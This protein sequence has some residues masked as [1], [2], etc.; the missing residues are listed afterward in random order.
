MI[1][2]EVQEESREKLCERQLA[3]NVIADDELAEST[4]FADH[5]C[6]LSAEED[7]QL[8]VL[9][10]QQRQVSL[11]VRLDWILNALEDANGCRERI[12]H[13][14]RLSLHRADA[15]QSHRCRHCPGLR[16]ITRRFACFEDTPEVSAAA[17]RLRAG[18]ALLSIAGRARTSFQ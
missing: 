10:E 17:L 14:Q 5:R 2:S 18:G 1:V 7:K 9:A 13:Q 8:A 12:S 4:P 16:G 15:E 11:G 6:G 3:Q